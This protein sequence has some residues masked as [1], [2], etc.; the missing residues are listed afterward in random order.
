[1]RA[2]RLRL[3]RSRRD[4]PSLVRRAEVRRQVTWFRS[5][6]TADLPTVP[7]AAFTVSGTKHMPSEIAGPADR[8]KTGHQIKSEPSPAASTRNTGGHQ[9]T[10]N[11]A[12]E[13][14]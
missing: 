5:A 11:R 2:Q 4:T 6:P 10:Y 7:A 3:S 1:M 9:Q 13:Q 8:G 14:N 12:V